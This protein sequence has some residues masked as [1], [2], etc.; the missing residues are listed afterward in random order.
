MDTKDTK[1]VLFALSLLRTKLAQFHRNEEEVED[2]D[3]IIQFIEDRV[4]EEVKP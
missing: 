3:Y 2:L 1:E 4:D